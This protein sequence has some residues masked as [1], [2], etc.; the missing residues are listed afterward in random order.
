MRSIGKIYNYETIKFPTLAVK[1]NQKQK[2][3]S[4]YE[5]SKTPLRYWD[6]VILYEISTWIVGTKFDF[7]NSHEMT[8]MSYNLLLNRNILRTVFNSTNRM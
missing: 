1:A 3:K 7:A 2:T 8:K 6:A 4:R 5:F